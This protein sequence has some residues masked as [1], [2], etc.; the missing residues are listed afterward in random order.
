M[1][2]IKALV[3]SPVLSFFPIEVTILMDE[4]LY[5]GTAVP[6]AD[7]IVVKGSIVKVVFTGEFDVAGDEVTGGTMTGFGVWIGNTKML[8]AEGYSVPGAALFD[9]IEIYGTDDDPFDE[10]IEGA[11]TEFVGSKY[12]D[13]LADFE[14]SGFNDLIRGKRGDDILFGHL[15][16][17]TLR[18]NKGNDWLQDYT[19]TNK[20]FGGPGSDT[21][22]FNLYSS[23]TDVGLSKI[24]DFVKG[25][26]IIN[27]LTD[28]PDLLP[29]ALPAN[30]FHKGTSAEGPDDYVIYDRAT[31]RLY[32][33]FDGSGTR[34]QVHFA[35]VTAGIKLQATDFVVGIGA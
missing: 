3:G 9:A 8:A 5:F 32:L 6:S 27:L 23:R 1:Q 11:A 19:G 18:G 14:G 31:G 22:A 34:D 28:I 24:K 21:F 16:D 13:L 29:G 25:E 17:D 30:F 7:E 4:A 12:G 20:F 15:G 35:S 33:D 10:L 2:Q 26:D